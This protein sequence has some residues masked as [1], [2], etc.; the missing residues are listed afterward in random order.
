MTD[1]QKQ[2]IRGCIATFNSPNRDDSASDKDALEMAL[3]A[4]GEAF[5]EIVQAY[6]KDYHVTPR[7]LDHD[8]I[9]ANCQA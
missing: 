3:F 9:L 2:A 7:Q 8:K 6:C 5:P 1:E 4:L